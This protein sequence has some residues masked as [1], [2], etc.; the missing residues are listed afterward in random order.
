MAVYRRQYRRRFDDAANQLAE[1]VF[2]AAESELGAEAGAGLL[3]ADLLSA[4]LLSPAGAALES[5]PDFDSGADSAA[6]ALFAA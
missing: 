3:S 2:V 6:G 5:P 1:P 4:A